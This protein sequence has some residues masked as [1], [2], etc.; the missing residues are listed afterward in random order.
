MLPPTSPAAMPMHHRCCYPISLPCW[1]LSLFSLCPFLLLG[2]LAKAHCA[3]LGFWVLAVFAPCSM[4]GSPALSPLC[5]ELWAF[6]P[7]LLSTL[8]T[9]LSGPGFN[10]LTYMGP[11]AWFLALSGL[12]SCPLGLRPPIACLSPVLCLWQG[13]KPHIPL[14][15]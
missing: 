3:G 6:W 12:C 1:G 15:L 2:H 7:Y 11:W 9:G 13:S 8:G 10:T 14:R 5:S 4:L